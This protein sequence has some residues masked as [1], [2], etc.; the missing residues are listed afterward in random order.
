MKQ[1][2]FSLAVGMPAVTGG[3]T[4]L[5]SAQRLDE[6]PWTPAGAEAV[7]LDSE[8]FQ[9]DADDPLL[10]ASAGTVIDDLSALGGCWG[11]YVDAA[12]ISEGVAQSDAEF[13]QFD[14]T[15]GVMTYQVIQRVNP[16][17]GFDT[18]VEIV[19]SLEVVGTDEIAI[20]ALT[21][22]TASMW[23][24]MEAMAGVSYDVEDEEPLHLQVIVDGDAFRFAD[25]LDASPDFSAPHR[26]GLV[27]KRLDCPETE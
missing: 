20:Q 2:L 5:L 7:E 22:R 1:G 10:A 17:F 18:A 15:E 16:L 4:L 11:A 3:C 27:F 12:S 8:T 19:Y 6:L 9:Y 24:E 13:Y 23:A 21:G 26:S 14:F 25:S